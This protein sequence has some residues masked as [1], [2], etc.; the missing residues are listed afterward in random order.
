S[1]SVEELLEID[2]IGQVMAEQIFGYFNEPHNVEALDALLQPSRL[3]PK[4]EESVGGEEESAAFAGQTF[5]F[6]GALERF[7]RE[8]AAELVRA[9]GGKASGSVSAKT[10]WLVAGEGGGSKLAKAQELGVE[11]L[12][13]EQ[14]VAMLRER[15]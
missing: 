7:S 9:L 3:M 15:A 6:T 11:V 12:D 13:E 1:A 4:P 10:T 2:G 5:V 14:F 8:Q